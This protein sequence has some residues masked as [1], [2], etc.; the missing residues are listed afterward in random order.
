MRRS[1][2]HAIGLLVALALMLAA[3]V[4][5]GAAPLNDDFANAL[6]SGGDQVEGAGNNFGATKEAGE[7]SHAGDPGGASVWFAWTAP[8]SQTVYVQIC[9]EGWPA[10]L[11]IYRGDSIGALSPVAATGI[12]S[13]SGSCADLS[14]RAISTVTYRIAIDGS[15]AGG[16]GAEEG[17]FDFT[18]SSP[19][20]EL[21][22]NDAFAN[23]AG[24]RST[25]EERIYGSTDGATREPGEP[26]HGGDL[27]GASVWYRWTAPVSAAMRLLPCEAGFRPELAV[28]RGSTLTSLE[29]VGTPAAL[30]SYQLAEC[31]LGGLGGVGFDAVAG[32]TYAFRVDSADGGWGRFQLRL[33]PAPVIYRDV[34]PPNTYIYKLQRL[35][36]RGIAIRF[37]AGGGPPGDTFLCKLDRRPFSPCTT[38]RKWRR[39]AV[40][41]HRVAVVATDAAGNRDA[42]PAV[43]TFKIGRKGKR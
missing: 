1:A 37:G 42:T 36:G 11:G 31:Q 41:S 34:Y 14:F 24:V 38:P 8:R 19:P 9:T 29:A 6:G 7:P 12:A 27:A 40:G 33:L 35:R 22:V 4:P 32:E 10:V 13:T 2:Q 23:A 25:T 30:G 21:P 5:A 17:N 15:T 26:G 18:V 3:A 43:R 39:L 20:L 28:Y 16:G